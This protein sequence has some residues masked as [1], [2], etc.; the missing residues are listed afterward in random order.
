[1]TDILCR[2]RDLR[3]GYGN[4]VE[5]AIAEIER[6][7]SRLRDALI[8][9]EQ[10]DQSKVALAWA[11]ETRKLLAGER[12]L[13]WGHASDC[14]VNNAPALPAGACDCGLEQSPPVTG[15]E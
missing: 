6:L 1:M 10:I 11:R 5:D 7:Q 2:L 9:A 13:A 8:Y 15:K 12:P 14:A 4:V 3:P